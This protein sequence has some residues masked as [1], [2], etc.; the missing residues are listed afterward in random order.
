MFY[1]SLTEQQAG[2]VMRA[3]DSAR[4]ELNRKRE[5]IK[6]RKIVGKE[7]FKKAQQELSLLRLESMQLGRCRNKLMKRISVHEHTGA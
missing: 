3:F 1:Y 4:R 2:V 7:D 5:R 6:N